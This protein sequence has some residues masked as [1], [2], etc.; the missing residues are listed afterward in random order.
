MG[1][2]KPRCRPRSPPGPIRYHSARASRVDAH[3]LAEG[4]VQTSLWGASIRTASR[5]SR[6]TSTASPRLKSIR[7]RRSW[8]RAANPATAQVAGDRGARHRRRAPRQPRRHGDRARG[9]GRGGR[10][11]SSHCARSASTP[12]PPRE[13]D[14]LRFTHSD[15]IAAAPHGEPP[16]LLGT[17]RSRW[18]FSAGVSGPVCLD[19]A[20][21]SIPWNRV[22]ERAARR[23][24]RARRG[25]ECRW[26][27]HHRCAAGR[28]A[29]PASAGWTAYRGCG[30]A[31][32]RWGCCA[33][34]CTK[35]LGAD[36]PDVRRAGRPPPLVPSCRVLDP[37]R[38]A[39]GWPSPAT[40]G[41]AR[42]GRRAGR[43][44]DARRPRARGRG[45]A[46]RRRHPHRARPRRRDALV[47]D[48]SGS[49]AAGTERWM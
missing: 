4:L 17:S 48:R 32:S 33:A 35:T 23:D 2:M 44:E 43:A 25:G 21:T 37:R 10:G 40:V 28:R 6:T 11:D 34:R 12:A 22:D 7:R 3:C 42:A 27:R 31:L 1:A 18:R 8:S 20:T 29:A 41:I 15:K 46:A 5:A 36:R 39:G 38:F 49:L 45:P 13:P 24:H 14:R 9:I 16:A 19:M 26:P 47:G 30:L